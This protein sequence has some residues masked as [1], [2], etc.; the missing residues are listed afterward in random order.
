MGYHSKA[1]AAAIAE[2][3]Q[4]KSPMPDN[5]FEHPAFVQLKKVCS[6]NYEGVDTFG[7]DTALLHALQSLGLPCRKS[8]GALDKHWSAIDVANKIDEAMRATDSERVHLVP[9][10]MAGNLP[11]ISF[12]P[13]RI[14]QMSPAELR[15]LVDI[16]RLKYTFP[17][18]DFDAE[19]FSEFT[20][21]IIQENFILDPKIGSRSLPMFYEKGTSILDLSID[22][23]WSISPHKRRYPAIVEEVLFFLLLAPWEDWADQP[24]YEW[25][26]FKVPWVYTIDRDIFTHL[27]KPPTP[28]TLTWSDA[29][30]TD[31]YGNAIEETVPYSLNS[32]DEAT[33]GLLK[34]DQI[35][36]DTVT[37]AKR[38]VLFETPIT[39]FMVHAFLG[40]EIDEFLAHITAIEA[41]L[42]QCKDYKNGGGSRNIKC[43]GTALLNDQNFALNYKNLFQKRSEYLH[44]R[45]MDNIP[46]DIRI[47]AR[48]TAR[49]VISKLIQA[50][51]IGSIQSREKYMDDLC[52]K[53]DK[54]LD[55]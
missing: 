9:L 8:E 41:A 31:K 15:D 38:S 52:V 11:E 46:A 51:K 33:A 6:D 25:R 18:L 47:L 54:L 40:E 4:I 43:R 14:K 20:W 10:D 28:D 34:W 50:T 27:W 22:N 7:F 53:G 24:E 12:G 48:S 55:T 17:R 19:R 2:L 26:G 5:I 35:Y 23:L 45:A 32:N 44:G 37:L 1:M 29:C 13:A 36:W 30:F 42:G 49:K 39:H 21:L 3:W 16:N